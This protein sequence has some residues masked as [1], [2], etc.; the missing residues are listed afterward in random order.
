[1]LSPWTKWTMNFGRAWRSTTTP[2]LAAA[3]LH[4]ASWWAC[5]ACLPAAY[6]TT[7]GYRYRTQ[8]RSQKKPRRTSFQTLCRLIYQTRPTST[9]SAEI[10]R[11]L[12]MPIRWPMPAQKLTGTARRPFKINHSISPFMVRDRPHDAAGALAGSLKLNPPSHENGTTT[13]FV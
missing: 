11:T 3:R 6:L 5:P 1:V 13:V 8:P 12:K 2:M 10:F 4:F 7:D 9:L